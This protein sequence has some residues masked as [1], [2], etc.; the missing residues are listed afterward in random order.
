MI[1]FHSDFVGK[2]VSEIVIAPKPDGSI[3]DVLIR[4]T[5]RSETF[6]GATRDGV[7]VS[8]PNE[9]D[10]PH[11]GLAQSVRKHDL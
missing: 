3:S 2:T 10:Q 1:Y 5:D 7:L 4:F 6:I 9:Q 11:G 8:L